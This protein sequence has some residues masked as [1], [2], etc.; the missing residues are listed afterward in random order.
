M[1]LPRAVCPDLMVGQTCSVVHDQDGDAKGRLLM[2]STRGLNQVWG[3]V[4]HN[5]C[6]HKGVHLHMYCAHVML[7]VTCQSRSALELVKSGKPFPP[8]SCWG[9]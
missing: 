9:H 3:Q 5:I 2:S 6:A 4:V 7:H 1:W 8:I